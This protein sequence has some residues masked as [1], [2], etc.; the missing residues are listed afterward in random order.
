MNGLAEKKERLRQ[1]L[2]AMESAAVAFSAGVDSSFLAKFA[3]DILGDR[4][5]AVTVKGAFMPKRE[6]EE[7]E[8]FCKENGI[9]QEIIELDAMSIAEFCNNTPDRCYHC[10]KWIFTGIKHAAARHGIRNI[11]DGSNLDDLSDYRPGMRALEELGIISPLRDAGL[12]KAEIRELSKELGLET[13]DKPSF[14]CL[15]TRIPTGDIITLEKLEM[16]EKAEQKLFELGFKQFRVRIHGRAA[17]IEILPEEFPH[18]L[19]PGTAGEINAYL[20]QLGF[21]FVTLD[22]GGYRT[23]STNL[24]ALNKQ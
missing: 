1:S 12:T 24:S 10:K 11:I 4:L 7:A 21:A 20:R 14:A 6:L 3:R 13:A 5:L 18:I 2:E 15:A 17:R 9:A 16:A 23:G 19:A 22:L 8:A